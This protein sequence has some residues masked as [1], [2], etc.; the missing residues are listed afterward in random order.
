MATQPEPILTGPVPS[1]SHKA[2]LPPGSL[3]HV[4]EAPATKS[5]VS[6]ISFHAD[7]HTEH[8]VHGIDDILR[9]CN[10]DAFVWV[11]CEGLDIA[12]LLAALGEHFKVHPL[13]LE[14]ILNTHQR[15]KFEEEDDYLFVVL[16][17]MTSDQALK[18]QY[19]QISMLLFPRMLITFREGQD[20]AFDGIRRRLRNGRGRIRSLGTDYLLYVVMDSVVDRYFTL[21]DT[22]EEA[23]EAV[24]VKLLARPRSQTFV[25]IQRLKR[26]LVFIR[27]VIAPLR[28]VLTAL[29][30]SDSP[31]I[32][33]RTLPYFRD[34]FDHTIRVI[35]TMD[36]FRDLING[37]LDIYL[38]SVSNRVNE[39]M[40][41][42]TVFATI[43]IPLTFLVGI[44]GMNFDYMPEL[45]WKWSYPIL[46]GLFF[47]IPAALLLW[48][49]KKKWL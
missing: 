43:F 47:L 23:I 41:V 49:K 6:L 5:R 33:A 8:P 46:W 40:K 32:Q 21:S 34:V 14:D 36:S 12:P 19:E 15:P 1:S 11:H 48:F 31:L 26:E 28:D 24:E 4:G 16:K 13:V 10:S 37:M 25:T 30:R 2:G 9:H 35:E 38:S 7:D 42:L 22:M 45:R 29:Q 20:D 39:V 18:V 3:V 27:K 17:T 44:Y